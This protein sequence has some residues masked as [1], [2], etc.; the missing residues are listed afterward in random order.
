M[1][2]FRYIII[3]VSVSIWWSSCII[4]HIV[5]K[6]VNKNIPNKYGYA[7]SDDTTSIAYIKWKNFFADPVLNGLIDTALQNNQELNIVLQELIIAKNEIREKKGEYLPF[8][9]IGAVSE[10]D[11]VGEYT[12]NGA[13][14]RELNITEEAPFPTPFSNY[15]LAAVAHWEVDIWKKLRN[16]KQAAVMRYMATVEGRNFLITQ[17]VAE[18]AENYYELL[19]LDNRLKILE[20]NAQIQRRAL[21]VMEQRKKAG[22]VTQLAVNRFRAQFLDTK[23]LI[24]QTKQQIVETENKI[25]F[26]TGRYPKP[27]PRNAELF[28]QIN[29]DTLS[30]GVPSQLLLNRPDVRQAEYMLQAAKLDVKS[31]RANFFP[32][33]GISAGLGFNAFKPGLLVNPASVMY[34]LAGDIVAPLVNR[35]AIKAY[36]L[37]ANAKQIQAAYKYEQT[38]VQAY[39]DV[40]NQLAK[41]QNYME[42]YKFKKQQVEVLDES[43]DISNSLF[44]WARADYGEVLLTQREVLDA[45]LE[46]IEIHL[47]QLEA[48]INLYRALGGGWR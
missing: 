1:K 2:N 41:I 23:S 48:K 25:N 15:A 27:I 18:I 4:P 20:T 37:S 3:I 43:V 32:S 21:K 44:R 33:L 29:L 24:Y 22:Q 46:L 36:Y 13:V 8:V 11:K 26:L 16:A 5:S 30:Q 35:N 12:R 9:N 38:L 14:E 7:L 19:A 39:T 47:K 28:F 42:S 31:A 34:N 40:L 6:D 10:L 17:L 45:K